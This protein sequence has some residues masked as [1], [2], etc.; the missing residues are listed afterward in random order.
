[1]Y[2]VIEAL[3]AAAYRFGRESDRPRMFVAEQQVK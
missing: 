2:A 1:M 3:S